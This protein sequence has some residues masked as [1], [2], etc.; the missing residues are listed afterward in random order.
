MRQ[1][2]DQK[3]LLLALAMSS[4]GL[5]A[6][7][8]LHVSDA[9]VSKSKGPMNRMYN[10]CVGAG[11]ANEGWWAHGEGKLPGRR[12][13]KIRVLHAGNAATKSSP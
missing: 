3:T 10:F 12:Q 7:P 11:R 8:A 13:S 5:L 2:H 6:G 1:L 9:D 4:L